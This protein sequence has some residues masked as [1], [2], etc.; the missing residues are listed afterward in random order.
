MPPMSSGSEVVG[1]ATRAPVVSEVIAF[2][3]IKDLST[4][5]RYAPSYRQRPLHSRHHD[6]VRASAESASST[7]GD[8]RWEGYQ[9]R[10]SRSRAPSVATNSAAA[11]PVP[12]D[13]VK[14]VQSRKESGPAVKST[15][16]DPCSIHGVIVP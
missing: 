16:P 11:E 3:V 7:I 14:G 5:S 13:N 2:S 15:P 8:P 12:S 10:I 4:C 6:S 1:A 9:L